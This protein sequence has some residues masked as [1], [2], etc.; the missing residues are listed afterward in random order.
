MGEA[1]N[2]ALKKQER[3]ARRAERREIRQRQKEILK[4]DR[5]GF[6]S[7]F[8]KFITKG[9]VLDLAV[10]VVISTAFNAIVNGLVKYIITPCVTYVTNG[11]SIEEWEYVLREA[12]EKMV[13][14]K[15]VEVAEISI[16]YGL[17]LQ[18]IVDFLII[19]LSIFVAVRIIRKAERAMNAKKIIMEEKALAAKKAEEDAKAAAAAEA[20]AAAAAEEKA[21]LAE[22]YANI[23]EQSELLRDIREALKK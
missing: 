2:K 18:A 16:Q 21:A 8:K 5:V 3:E 13:D 6:F 20:A 12:G 11:K 1:D 4:G 7:D 9:N 19:A 23:K 10:A 22:F 15:A 17:W 14:G